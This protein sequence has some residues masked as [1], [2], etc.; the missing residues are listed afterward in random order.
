MS[1]RLVILNNVAMIR[2]FWNYA[3]A[4][5]RPKSWRGLSLLL[6]IFLLNFRFL[7]GLLVLF[8]IDEIFFLSGGHFLQEIKW[9][10][11]WICWLIS[12]V[13]RLR[14][15]ECLRGGEELIKI[16]SKLETL[17]FL[18]TQQQT[19]TRGSSPLNFFSSFFMGSTG[20]QRSKKWKVKRTILA[21]LILTPP[22]WG[23]YNALY[24]YGTHSTHVNLTSFCL[25]CSR[26]F[27]WDNMR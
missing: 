17:S 16:Q 21:G 14:S 1:P 13:A 6:R 11:K 10:E 27:G 26:L 20:S 15:D 4:R 12:V 22:V 24:N 8:V 25:R 7:C 9:R 3:H 23:M 19:H 2:L 18:R 5:P